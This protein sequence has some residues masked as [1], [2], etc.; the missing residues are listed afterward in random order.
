[1]DASK[2]PQNESGHSARRTTIVRY[3]AP[4]LLFLLGVM[5][6]FYRGWD[7]ERVIWP[8]AL[9]QISPL[10]LVLAAPIALWLVL[11]WI[12]RAPQQRGP[13]PRV[14]GLSRE[15]AAFNSIAE[16]TNEGLGTERIV[17]YALGKVLEVMNMKEG[18]IYL[19]NDKAQELY[20][21][22]ERWLAPPSKMSYKAGRGTVLEVA[23]SG[24]PVILDD[25]KSA[26][27][28]KALAFVPLK[29]KDRVIGVLQL[30]SRNHRHFSLGDRE[31]LAAFGNQIAVAVDNARLHE[32]SRK[33][34]NEL[35]A[36]H[37]T[38]LDVTSQLATPAVLRAIV[39]RATALLDGKGGGVYL[40]DEARAR[41]IC[42]VS[43]GT[44]KDYTGQVIKPREGLVG[45]VVQRGAPMIVEE[46]RTWEGKAGELGAEEPKTAVVAAPLRWQ[47]QVT[48]A[49]LVLLDIDKRVPDSGDLQLL[50]LFAN[51][52][53][54]AVQNARLYSD[55]NTLLLDSIQALADAVEA[56]DGYTAGHSVNIATYCLAIGEELE[57]SSEEL[58]S[59]HFGALLHDIGKIGISD[60]ILRKAGG[61]TEQEYEA[62]KEHSAIG[63]RIAER[64][65][66][67][68]DVVP[69]IYHHQERFDGTGYPDGLASDEIPLSARILAVADAFGAMTT[70]RPYR[71]ALSYR[72]ALQE[73]RAGAGTQF[74]P[75]VVDAFLKVLPQ[76]LG[77]APEH[78][79]EKI[80]PFDRREAQRY[81]L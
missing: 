55:L 50:A 31:I 48:G 52:A 14:V 73:L 78:L 17:D 39:E 32:E 69:I 42:V 35:A 53:A 9:D 3:L 12:E 25:S 40:K 57:L 1:M 71:P 43:L 47:K 18:A 11:G 61:L 41:L 79:G 74:D 29:S 45:R 19:V 65:G 70:T 30:C 37:Q 8:P 21:A 5:V 22:A 44:S 72:Q 2:N 38:S 56:R 26:E 34:F 75:L 66:L 63:A 36:L 23:S 10:L 59:L 46:Y 68:R 4:T 51:Q 54:V 24:I 81:V 49:I 20:M 64:I 60:I 76:V 28:W 62:M 6:I 27:R 13:L 16:T 33:T 80:V 7:E 58:E 77:V 15:L 67:L